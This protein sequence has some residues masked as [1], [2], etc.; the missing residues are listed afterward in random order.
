MALV[1]EMQDMYTNNST[2]ALVCEQSR[3]SQA[4]WNFAHLS[5]GGYTCLKM[6]VS[7]WSWECKHGSNG[8]VMKHARF[9]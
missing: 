3:P 1:S 4:Y 8:Q 5:C 2:C 6:S 7:K 9:K